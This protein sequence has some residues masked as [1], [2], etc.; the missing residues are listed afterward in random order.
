[1][2]ELLD[3]FAC[4][5]VEVVV[6]AAPFVV[7]IGTGRVLRAKRARR[8]EAGAESERC[9]L[10]NAPAREEA[11]GTGNMRASHFSLP[12]PCDSPGLALPAH[13][14][15]AVA[16]AIICDSPFPAGQLGGP[17]YRNGRPISVTPGCRRSPARGRWSGGG[18][19]R[20]DNTSAARDR[21]PAGAAPW[22]GSRAR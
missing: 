7:G 19:C 2:G 12:F 17:T 18:G 15:I 1:M 16:H 9:R 22:R 14:S 11:E 10:S 3:Q 6:D 13:R 5:L 20:C 4:G 8:R 21:C